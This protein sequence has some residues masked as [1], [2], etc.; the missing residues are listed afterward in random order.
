MKKKIIIALLLFIVIELASGTFGGVRM[1]YFNENL[2]AG[3]CIHASWFT[4]LGRSA[5]EVVFHFKK[6]DKVWSIGFRG[7][8][9]DEKSVDLLE[10]QLLSEL[11]EIKG[12]KIEDGNSEKILDEAE[13]YR[14]EILIPYVVSWRCKRVIKNLKKDGVIIKSDWGPFLRFLF[15][16]R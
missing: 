9:P 8:F 16:I 5:S 6:D 1:L 14:M 3:E 13:L 12:T 15:P 4:T 2:S 7:G 10:K 11:H